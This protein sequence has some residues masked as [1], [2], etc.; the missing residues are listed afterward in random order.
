MTLL[1]AIGDSR[2]VFIDTSPII[3]AVE[4]SARWTGVVL[5]LFRSIQTG[6]VEAVTSVVT[7]TEIMAK[8]LAM[9]NS[10]LARFYAGVLLNRRWF[11]T[12]PISS[13]SAAVAAGLRTRY[14]LR[15]PDA[16]QIA[17][18][19]VEGC[20]TFVTNDGNLKRV[21]DLPVVLLS[22]CG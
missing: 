9:G 15:T 13:E 10:A 16:L 22:E 6:L 4:P 5:P 20:D 21:T 18:A 12:T 14:G 1:E 11:R 19:L 17:S 3:Y 8:P 7:L 2:H